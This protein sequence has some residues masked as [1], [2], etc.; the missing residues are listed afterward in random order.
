MWVFK[1]SLKCPNEHIL[2][3]IRR[4]KPNCALYW[5]Y[6]PSSLYLVVESLKFLCVDKIFVNWKEFSITFSF[7]RCSVFYFHLAVTS[8]AFVLIP[9]QLFFFCIVIVYKQTHLFSIYLWNPDRHHALGQRGSGEQG[10]TFSEFPC[11]WHSRWDRPSKE[12]ML[13][14]VTDPLLDAGQA[15]NGVS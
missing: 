15:L 9:P 13:H 11:W 6:I 8:N 3:C 12:Q 4:R 14:R 5:K 7:H 10:T 1:G 2:T